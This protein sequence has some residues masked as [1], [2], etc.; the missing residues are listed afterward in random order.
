MTTQTTQR[1]RLIFSLL[2]AFAYAN[3]IALVAE[4]AATRSGAA[5]NVSSAVPTPAVAAPTDYVIGPDDILDVR[6]WKEPDLS[7][8][9]VVRPDGKISLPML[10]DVPAAGMKPEQLAEVVEK[11]AQNYVRDAQATV[12][13]KAINSRKITIIGQ[14][15]KSG[16]LPL[17]TGMTVLQAIGEAG[18]FTEDANKNDVTIVRIENGSERRYKFNYNEVVKGKKTQQ[19]ILLLPGDTIIVR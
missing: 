17:S 15:G 6:V 16:S 10:N 9:V 3:S 11:A 5:G 7:A 4:Q 8:E 13:V 18:G 2:V 19:N 1:Q 14:V 12:M